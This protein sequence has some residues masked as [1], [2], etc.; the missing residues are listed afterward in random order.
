MRRRLLVVCFILLIGLN[1]CGSEEQQEVTP[2]VEVIEEPIP[3]T[4]KNEEV[5]STPV[6]EKNLKSISVATYGQLN[7]DIMNLM[8]E[9]LEQY[10]YQ[11][12]IVNCQ[13][14]NEVLTKTEQSEVDLCLGVNQ[15]L[16]DSY[17]KKNESNLLIDERIYLSPFAIFAGS[18]TDL[19]NIPSG[20]KVYVEEGS[21]NMARALHLLAQK[22]LIELKPDG[23]Y[24]TSKEDIVSNA[25]NLSIEPCNLSEGVKDSYGLIICDRNKAVI[26]GIDPSTKLSEENRN[27]SLMDMFTVC[28]IVRG[29]KKDSE[30]VKLFMK[31]I[32]SDNVENKIKETFGDGVVDYK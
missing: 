3:S 10:G 32:N 11:V 2:E 4:N 1:A 24:Q 29:D 31:A 30:G 18:V 19:N 15:V 12:N 14:Y 28:A 21:V 20:T 23:G 16:Y 6:E 26:Y 17:C 8:S 9:E 13:D 25:K 5:S 7:V 22:G 27:S